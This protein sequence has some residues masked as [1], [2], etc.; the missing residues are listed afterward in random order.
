MVVISVVVYEKVYVLILIN[1]TVRESS[2]S[3]LPIVS[4]LVDAASVTVVDRFFITVS[5][6]VFVIVT[7]ALLFLDDDEL[8]DD[9][10]EIFPSDVEIEVFVETEPLPDT[11]VFVEIEPPDAEA[12]AVVDD[13]EFE[14][15][16][17]AFIRIPM[18]SF[19]A[20]NFFWANSN[21][22]K[23]ALILPVVVWQT[24]WT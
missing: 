5:E 7:V 3:L 23:V 11:E 20:F 2:S 6:Y 17:D 19:A 4:M 22:V 18:T 12:G 15:D 24:G 9:S 13:D 21:L 1:I 14:E 8:E 10:T 16:E